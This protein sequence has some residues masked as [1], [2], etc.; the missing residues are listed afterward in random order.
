MEA[1]G[2]GT[3][4]MEPVAAGIVAELK[5]R[6]IDV[7]ILDPFVSTHHVDE[8]DNSKIQRVAEQWVHVAE[9]ADCAVKVVHHVVKRA[10]G[11]Y[12][13]DSMRGAGAL[14]DKARKV[15]V[16]NP[17]TEK[18]AGE[19]RINPEDADLYFRATDGK[20]NMSRRGR[21]TGI[22]FSPCA[23]R[24]EALEISPLAMV[25]RL[26]LSWH[27]SSNKTSPPAPRPR[28]LN[29]PRKNCRSS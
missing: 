13:A 21:H 19:M 17:M 28:W 2:R 24:T 4:V 22:G 14:K 3:K 15:R 10:D 16:L 1:D 9:E 11:D 8:N 29:L 20:T 27:G 12:T 6:H 25:M 18:L 26:A 7:L 5:A 23:S